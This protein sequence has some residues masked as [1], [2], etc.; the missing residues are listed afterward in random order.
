MA[1]EASEIFPAFDIS[2]LLKLHFRLLSFTAVY[3]Q[4]F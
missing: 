4:V 2:L 1:Y 3:D